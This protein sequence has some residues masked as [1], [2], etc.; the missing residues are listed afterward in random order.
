MRYLLLICDDPTAE[1]YDAAGDTIDEWVTALEESGAYV[2]G[3]R[4][5]PIED[6]RTVRVRA[7]EVSVTEAPFTSG[8]VTLA[9]FDVIEA[10]DRDAAV[11]VA[12]RHPMARFGAIEVRELWPFTG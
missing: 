9:G 4:L 3:D 12:S 11:E 5:R 7:G 6:A 8:P 1:P 10:P 2:I